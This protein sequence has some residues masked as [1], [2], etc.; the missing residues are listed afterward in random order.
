MNSEFFISNRRRLIE[1]FGGTAPIIL[2]ANSRLQRSVDNP[3]PFDQDSNFWYLTG[4]N[5]PGIILVMDKG[6]EYL[7]VPALSDSRVA[8]EGSIDMNKLQ[9]DSGIKTV[10]DMEAGW[11]KLDKRIKKVKRIATLAQPPVYIDSLDMFTNPSRGRLVTKILDINKDVELIDLR[12]HLSR[13]RMIKSPME[14][15]VMQ[16]AINETIKVY[17]LIDQTIPKSSNEKDILKAV[18]KYLIE[19]ELEFAYDPIVASGINAVTLHYVQ[20]NAVFNK[21]LPLLL[22]IAVRKNG[23][24]ADITR[25]VVPEPTKRQEA[26]Y[27]AVLAVQEFACSL[28]KPG[29]DIKTYDQAVHHYMGEKLSELGLIR[30]IDEDSIREYYPHSTSHFLGIDVHDVADYDQPLE[31]GMVLTVEPGIYIRSEKIGIRLED[32]ILITSNGHKNLSEKLPKNIR[33]LTIK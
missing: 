30:T 1:A 12:T 25:T 19:N 13:L 23:Y 7:I 6:Q 10:L 31:G 32:D 18:Q 27:E 2:T 17:K 9:K 16:D 28:L 22:D 4:I 14:I 24:N 11:E 5:E 8:F 20:N 21:K 15:E 33:S 26:V 29:T 3:Y